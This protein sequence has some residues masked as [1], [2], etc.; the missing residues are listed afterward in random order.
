MLEA[1]ATFLR[2]ETC[3]R[4][5]RS[6]RRGAKGP[7]ALLGL[8]LPR[9][10]R[11][12]HYVLFSNGSLQERTRNLETRFVHG[13][14]P[15]KARAR[16]WKPDLEIARLTLFGGFASFSTQ[17]DPA[18]LDRGRWFVFLPWRTFGLLVKLTFLQ[19]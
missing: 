17:A 18:P 8:P 12:R 11:N 7:R 14:F 2:T 13:P 15:G 4:L 6:S 9:I 19:R 1:T 3:T 5:H 10:R 16:N